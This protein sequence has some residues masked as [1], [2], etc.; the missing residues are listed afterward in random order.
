MRLT[1]RV[2]WFNAKKGYGFIVTD[3]GSEEL[4]V[5]YSDI[6][7]DGFKTLREGEAV[8]FE[9]V[10]SPKGPKAVKVKRA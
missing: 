4:F 5:H 1:G 9:K 8:S 7:I 6:E 10:D 2:K 3:D